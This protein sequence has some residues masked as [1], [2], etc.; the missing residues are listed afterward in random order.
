[1]NKFGKFGP[2]EV[3]VHTALPGYTGV[4]GNAKVVWVRVFGYGIHARW[5]CKG[6]VPYFSERN[7]YTKVLKLG[8]LWF[9]ALTPRG[10]N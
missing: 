1:M 7:G 9:K 2:V 8:R 5:T 10:L 6:Y 4:M 3:A